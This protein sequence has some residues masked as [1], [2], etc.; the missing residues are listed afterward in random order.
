MDVNRW[1][2][3]INFVDSEGNR[4]SSLIVEIY[5]VESATAI[6]NLPRLCIHLEDQLCWMGNNACIFSVGNCYKINCMEG[7]N[8]FFLD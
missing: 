6:L 1:V 2:K 8:F 5:T 4:N 3:I 7:Q